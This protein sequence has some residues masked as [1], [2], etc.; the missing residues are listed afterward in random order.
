[1]PDVVE[2]IRE[3]LA[4]KRQDR[5]SIQAD[6]KRESLTAANKANKPADVPADVKPMKKKE[7]K[8]EEP[9]KEVPERGFVK[10]LVRD[11]EKSSKQ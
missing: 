4:K 6:Q 11:M 10:K 2:M 8:K 7:P 9:K 5:Q 3:H 1:M